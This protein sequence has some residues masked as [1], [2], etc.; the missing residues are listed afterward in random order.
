MFMVIS[1]NG[2]LRKNTLATVK[3]HSEKAVDYNG[4]SIANYKS[5]IVCFLDING[6]K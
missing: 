2:H 5:R 6:S 1:C 3:Q 4:V